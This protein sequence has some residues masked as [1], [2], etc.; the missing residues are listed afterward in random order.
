MRRAIALG[1]SSRSYR[2][3]YS[4]TSVSYSICFGTK[5]VPIDVLSVPSAPGSRRPSPSRRLYSG[6]LG[7]AV[8]R[9]NHRDLNSGVD[10]EAVLL[11]EGLH[12]V[13]VE[14]DDEA[15]EDVEAV[16]V[17]A[18]HGRQDVLARVLKLLRLFQAVFIR[19]F[20]PDEHPREVRFRKQREQLIVLRQIQRR[21]GAELE[22]VIMLALV[23]AEKAKEILGDVLVADEIVVDEK[24]IVGMECAQRVELAPDLL[25][26]FRARLAP[27]HD[28]DVAEFAEEWT[29]ARKLQAD[30]GVAVELQ[31]IESRSGGI[32]E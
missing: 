32:G 8:S 22:A 30:V 23:I 19:G 16:R 7:R 9:P 5:F 28:D 10:D 18:A 1:S 11:I 31:Q 12:R 13:V 24:D 15:R 26:R 21:L 17:D 20:D 3:R 25:A 4:R 2:C 6:V 29:T 14:P 27:E